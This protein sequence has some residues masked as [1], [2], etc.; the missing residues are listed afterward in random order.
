MKNYIFV[1][2]NYKNADLDKTTILD[3]IKL[4]ENNFNCKNNNICEN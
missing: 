4:G 1:N 2:V 3:P